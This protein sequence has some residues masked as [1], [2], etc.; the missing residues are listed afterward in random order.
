MFVTAQDF[1]LTPFSIPNLSS[2]LNTFPLYINEQEED[3]LTKILG[4]LF[5]DKLYAG[6]FDIA[7]QPIAAPA[8]R[9]K[10]IR[11]G[12]NYNYL[13]RVYKWQGL[14]KALKPYIYAM[15]LRDNY[16]SDTGVGVVVADAEN[17]VQISPNR[18]I[19]RGYNTFSSHIG[20]L[21]NQKHNLYGFLY[22]SGVTYNAD[23]AEF[24][25]GDFQ[26]Y[27]RCEFKDPGTMNPFNL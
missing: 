5:Y 16:D 23:V 18:R 22:N 24:G 4:K 14:K 10:A 26:E 11:D 3:R 8:E 2:V 12:G 17:S 9:W 15:W 21:C 20:N 1:N 19:C 13:G 27:L 7:G 6:L 25:Y